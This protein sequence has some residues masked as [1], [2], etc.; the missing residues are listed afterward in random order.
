MTIPVERRDELARKAREIRF[1][2][3]ETLA[4]ALE[5]GDDVILVVEGLA[6]LVGVEVD[7]R[8]WTLQF[9]HA[10]NLVDARRLNHDDEHDYAVVAM[11]EGRALGIPWPAFARL[12]ER[13]P[14]LLIE[15]LA[16]SFE[17]VS[18]LADRA[19]EMQALDVRERLCRLL[20]DFASAGP[21]KEGGFVAL[22]NPISHREIAQAVGASR[23]HTSA[24]LGELET[25]GAVVRRGQQGL[26]VHPRRLEE[27]IEETPGK[28]G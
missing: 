5:S 26:L 9:L 21:A 25:E 17:T 13:D 4:S 20:L 11:S 22:A 6:K 12:A 10:G 27:L 7:G 8:R 24:I 28:R 3:G 2:K 14:A 23:P 16:D 15:A 1:R 19:L 18:R